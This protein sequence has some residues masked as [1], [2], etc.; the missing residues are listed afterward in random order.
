[1]KYNSNY[2]KTYKSALVLV[3]TVALSTV[4]YFSDQVSYMLRT[5]VIGFPE[6]APFDGTTYPVKKVPNW[7]KLT[8]DER[9]MTYSELRPELL[10]ETPKYDPTVISKSTDGLSWSSEAD[11][12]V[13]NTKITYSV[14]YMGNYMFDGLENAGSHAAIDIKIPTGTPI[15]A[16]AN[17]TVIKASNQS[18]GFG[19]HIVVR[20]NNVPSA[21]DPNNL[22]VLYSSYS[23]LSD[24]LV[25]PGQIVTKGEQIAL[26]GSTGTATTPHLHFQIDTD[27]A[28]WHPFW[29][30]DWNDQ[31]AAGGIDFFT[32]INTGLGR[33]KALSTTVNPM[34]YVQ[35]YMSGYTGVSSNSSTSASSVVAS[36][37]PV[38]ATPVVSD[39]ADSVASEV[40]DA[41]VEET[42]EVSEPESVEEVA[43]EDVAEKNIL[44][45]EVLVENQYHQLKDSMYKISLKNSDGSKFTGELNGDI[46]ISSFKGNFEAVKP[47][48][49]MA[50]FDAN[51]EYIG[52]MRDLNL[53]KDKIYI[54]YNGLS[55][56]SSW[57]DIIGNKSS[58]FADVPAGNKN[59]EAIMY[60]VDAGVVNGYP[61]GTFRPNNTVSRVEAL[62]FIFEGIKE[63]LNEGNLPFN[64]VSESDWYAKYLYTAYSKGVVNGYSD[65]RFKPAQTVN[66][67]EFYK[68]LFN[69]MGVDVNPN[70]TE[71]PFLDVAT[72][73]WFAPYAAY[74][75]DLGIIDPSVKY[76]QASQ[77][78]SR[79][80]VAD[81]IYRLMQVM[82]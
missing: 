20:H 12:N 53:G 33:E 4:V 19:H 63:A 11:N 52:K 62:K 8:T 26:S 3:L 37:G 29:P 22:V 58:K 66:K 40:I 49:S 30:F 51:G 73:D 42:T 50:D 38:T 15:F 47:V 78:M 14:P 44:K 9:K 55:T 81:A 48:L 46:N 61:D 80:E 76:L 72:D 39:S 31:Q 7:V 5:S 2:F 71:Q 77:G 70:I 6:H 27:D 18:S 23:H 64:D 57:F 28:P 21:N 24:V 54:Q 10:V 25:S 79:G 13:R 82:K 65:G 68:I 59:E 32:A 34:K 75:K 43:I 36:E 41:V 67:A 74:A 16:I 35:S 17:G 1:M 45:F 60:L 69:G 56:Y